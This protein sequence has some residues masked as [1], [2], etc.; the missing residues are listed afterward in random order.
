MF[1]QT[2]VLGEFLLGGCTLYAETYKYAKDRGFCNK[3]DELTRGWKKELN[4]VSWNDQT[5]EGGHLYEE[6]RN[7]VGRQ[8][9]DHN[10]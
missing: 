10:G 4:L 7:E 3:V 8:Y 1:P 5:Q 6:L 2:N 9:I